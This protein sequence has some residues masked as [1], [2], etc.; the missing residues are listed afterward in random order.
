MGNLAALMSHLQPGDRVLTSPNFHIAYWEGDALRRVVGV[1]VD[2]VSDSTEGARTTIRDWPAERG[3]IRLLC[4]ET[5]VNRH[6]GTL[7]PLDHLRELQRRA[8]EWQIPVH[9]DGARFFNASCAMGVEPAVLAACVDSV[10]VSFNKALGA[11]AGAAV[12][13]SQDLVERARRFRWML[14]GAWKQGGVLAA[15]CLVG[16]Q[17]MHERIAADHRLARELA[18]GL[19][20]IPGVQ[21]DLNQVATNL[22]FMRIVEPNV[23]L[24]ALQI[25]LREHGVAIGRFKPPGISRLVTH[26]N[27]RPETIPRFLELLA[28]LLRTGE[29]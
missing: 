6:G 20:T 1:D 22:V 16:L 27:I 24:A 14:G 11:P 23:D 8:S 5:P 28:R 2:Y 15:A 21:V 12:A 18:Q 25:A 17:S 4:L 13:A 3:R 10:T 9:L 29:S 7:L 19:Q 26:Q